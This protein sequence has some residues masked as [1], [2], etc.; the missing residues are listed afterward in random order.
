MWLGITKII[1]E[2][3]INDGMAWRLVETIYSLLTVTEM[4]DD[5]KQKW[6]KCID[7]FKE[8]ILISGHISYYLKHCRIFSWIFTTR[9]GIS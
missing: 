6:Q 4:T 5:K 2:F 1:K 9:L 3:M 8:M 7:Y